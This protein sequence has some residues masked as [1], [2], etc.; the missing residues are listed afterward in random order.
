MLLAMPRASSAAA[1]PSSAIGTA[2]ITAAGVIQ[3]S[4][5]PASAKYTSRID[6]AKMK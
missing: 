3:L 4:Y 1:V 5:C 6:S 2:R